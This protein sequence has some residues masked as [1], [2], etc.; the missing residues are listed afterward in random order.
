MTNPKAPKATNILSPPLILG[1]TYCIR[2]RQVIIKVMILLVSFMHQKEHYEQ[3][4]EPLREKRIQ[5]MFKT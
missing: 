1:N 5:T 2:K 3:D 4:I